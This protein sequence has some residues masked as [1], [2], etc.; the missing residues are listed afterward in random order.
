MYSCYPT[1]RVIALQLVS[2]GFARPFKDGRTMRQ[3]LADY[4]SSSS[5]ASAGAASLGTTP[6]LSAFA[7]AVAV[8][9]ST[10]SSAAE[11][12][13]SS[14]SLGTSSSSSS[15]ASAFAFLDV[16]SS[17]PGAVLRFLAGGAASVFY[18]SAKLC[19]GLRIGI[20]RISYR[21]LQGSEA[22]QSLVEH[23]TYLQPQL[24]QHLHLLHLPRLPRCRRKLR[25]LLHRRLLR[26][27]CAIISDAIQVM[28]IPGSG[29]P[30]ALRNE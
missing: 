28:T 1:N 2:R 15:S 25:P 17:D 14:S 30:L 16:C 13:S 5:S 8:E 7:A 23:L 9:S 4:S 10:S 6:A 3:A 22:A 29:W 19:S 20:A 18:L 27:C 24:L 21:G 12:S 26:T 11:S